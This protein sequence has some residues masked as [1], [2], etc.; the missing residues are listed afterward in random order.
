MMMMIMMMMIMMMMIMM[1]I[2]MMLTWSVVPNRAM[3][4]HACLAIRSR[5][6]CQ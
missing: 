6:S 3:I 1:M 2:M 4:T 5:R